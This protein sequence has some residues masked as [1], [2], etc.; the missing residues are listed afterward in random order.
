MIK[1][2]VR[3]VLR[4]VRARKGRTFLVSLAIFIGVVGT[5]SLFSMS[6]ILVGQLKSDI[7]QDLLSM[8]QAAVVADTGVE[9]DD[10]AYI[11]ML[12]DFPGVTSIM[13][14]IEETPI[15]FKKTAGDEK[16]EEG[17]VQAYLVLNE[18]GTELL[19]AP[20][21][22]DAPMEPI[23]LL[24]G[25]AWPAKGQNEVAVERRMADEYGLNVGD[26]LYLRI[27][28]PSRDP[29]Q[30][31]ATGTVEVWTIAGIVFDPYGVY[32]T[33]NIYT[34]HE[35][36]NYL[37]G[38]TGLNDIWV[39]FD[40]F[41]AAEDS[42]D[43]FLTEIA[44]KTPYTPAFALTEDPAKNQLVTGAETI[45]S[46]MSMLALISLIVSGFLVI[47]V[48][49]SIVTEQKRQIGVMK[50]MGA[51]RGDNFFIYSGIAFMYGLIGV[52]PGVIVGIPAGNAISH[53][54]APQ[55]NTYLEGYEIS[56]P[57]IL[58]GIGV[59]LVVPVVASLLPVF[60]GTRVQILDAMTD[61]GIGGSYGSGP[62]ARLIN[63]LPLPVTV[64]QG[65]SN[66]SMK[67]WRLA[68]TV[69]TLSIA[70]GAFMGIFA[71]FTSLRDGIQI[72]I[73]SFNVELALF[74]G[75]AGDPDEFRTVLEENF[76]DDI[77]FLEEGMQ[78]Q[79]EFQ[80]YEPPL[81]TG[82]PPGIF[83]YGYNI[84]SEHPAF[85][86]EIKEGNELTDE[87]RETG[88]I[89]SSLLA[90]NMNKEVGDSVVLETPGGNRELDV[91]GIVEFPLDQCWIDWMMLAEVA[92]FTY[93]S[94][95][96][97]SALPD[98]F[99]PSEA[100][101][102]IKYATAVNVGGYTPADAELPGVPVLGLLPIIGQFLPIPDDFFTQEEPGVLI[103]GAMA[104]ASGLGEGDTL[105]L[106]SLSA[107]GQQA[108]SYP[109]AGVI[110]LPPMFSGAGIPSDFVGMNWRDAVA[111]DGGG[112]VSKPRPGG[113]FVTTNLNNPSADE[114]DDVADR[115]NDTL[116]GAGN[117]AFI[118]NF[119]A[120]T[121]EI[122]DVFLTFQVILSAVAGLIA[123]VGA[124]G[125]LTTLSMSVFE[126]QKE[127]GV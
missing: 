101:A 120:L 39:R 53:A 43:E 115:M 46:L 127:I 78:L 92:G 119:V 112:I 27:L 108:V 3:K 1:T 9:L 86:F 20:F 35:D 34:Y 12:G 118:L 99:L 104:E 57:S 97:D 88:I 69:A 91:V 54:L 56:L 73:D 18:D 31:G 63:A 124:L 59:G 65:L 45:A 75:T 100:G 105:T 14:G 13:T 10:A 6:D 28:S 55:L 42:F 29:E 80:G 7:K 33:V 82:G 83:A 85:N 24:E 121:D 4:D 17:Y 98:D 44:E 111:L 62:I 87:T 95:S 109:I 21:A 81:S 60:N 5:I 123:L 116:A 38:R 2:R 102:F 110:D 37:S 64:R 11:R 49:T 89:L 68:F 22:A 90:A 61:L 113:F 40:D 122:S 41:S 94:I 126:R 103:S 48:V 23:R 30:N 67:K 36:A 26:T 70:V 66:V 74:P 47:N 19:D 15:Y 76:A 117:P 72:F 114:L 93:D 107:D 106:S 50:S 51:T 79:V 8:G 25:G 96:A 84:D 71:L 16:F 32:S 125:L 52:I 58:M 77:A